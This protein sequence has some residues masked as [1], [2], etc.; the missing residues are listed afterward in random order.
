[1]QGS[2]ANYYVSSDQDA[3]MLAK[4]YMQDDIFTNW[5]HGDVPP[6]NN[7]DFFWFSKP[8]LLLCCAGSVPSTIDAEDDFS[9]RRGE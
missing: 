8:R 6:H 7:F 4:F 5:R 9:S 3:Y 2:V 1:L